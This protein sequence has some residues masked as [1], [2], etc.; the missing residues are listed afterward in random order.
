MAFHRGLRC[1]IDDCPLLSEPM[2]YRVLP[3]SSRSCILPCPPSIPQLLRVS[4]AYT[5]VRMRGGGGSYFLFCV[6]TI[7]TQ[8]T[9]APFCGPPGPQLISTHALKNCNYKLKS[10]LVGTLLL[11]HCCQRQPTG[12][13]DPHAHALLVFWPMLKSRGLWLASSAPVEVGGDN[14]VC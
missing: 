13:R 14:P 8:S 3:Q 4:L 9:S 7:K 11:T 12:T 2:L 6:C 5:V 10:K 1:L